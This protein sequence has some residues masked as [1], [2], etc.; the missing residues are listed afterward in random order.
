VTVV[1]RKSGETVGEVSVGL[2][3]EGMSVSPDSKVTV[4]TSETTSMAHSST[5][6]RWNC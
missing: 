4:A 6:T 5:T 1:D 3:P 2:E